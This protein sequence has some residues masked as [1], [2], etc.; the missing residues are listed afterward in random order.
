VE[1]PKEPSRKG[2]ESSPETGRPV[3]AIVRRDCRATMAATAVQVNDRRALAG[4]RLTWWIAG[5]SE[6]ARMSMRNRCP[7]SM[8]RKRDS[9]P[10][11]QSGRN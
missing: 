8:R 2:E 1:I 6:G 11:R 3:L 4:G 7:G 10:A 5:V 9:A